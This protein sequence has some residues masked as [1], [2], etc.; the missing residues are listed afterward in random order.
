MA[1]RIAIG[2]AFVREAVEVVQ[3]VLVDVL[4]PAEQPAELRELVRRRQLAEDQQVGR[5]DEARALGELL[6]GVA[7]ITE[8]ALAR[9][10]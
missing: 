10:R 2:G 3:H 1:D 8:D 7:A 4:V 6:D 5:L 9:R